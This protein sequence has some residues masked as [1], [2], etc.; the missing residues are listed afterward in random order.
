MLSK[1][2]YLDI[3][4]FNRFFDNSEMIWKIC[5]SKKWKPNVFF[6]HNQPILSFCSDWYIEEML[7]CVCN[8][9]RLIKS[10]QERHNKTLMVS[11]RHLNRKG[12]EGIIC[13]LLQLN[14]YLL[15]LFPHNYWYLPEDGYSRN[16]LGKEHCV[17]ITIVFYCFITDCIV[18]FFRIC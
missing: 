15:S 13:V 16:S 6:L 8:L 1:S 10:L 5:R 9:L 18:F 17:L 12:F 3:D 14:G 7:I 4:F 11:R 2:I